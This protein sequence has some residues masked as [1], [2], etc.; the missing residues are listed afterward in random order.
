MYVL[1]EIGGTKTRVASSS[2]LTSFDEPII[3]ETPQDYAA[4][5]EQLAA[6]IQ[7]LG[8]QPTAIACGLPVRLTRDKRTIA[9]ARNLPA[10]AGKNFAADLEAKCGGTVV[11]ENDV[12]MVGL[13]EAQFGAG[14]GASSIIYMTVST[15]V[16]AVR[17]ADGEIDPSHGQY[18]LGRQYVPASATLDLEHLV[19]GKTVCEKYGVASPRDLGA[20]SA[21]WTELAQTLSYGVHNA[22]LYWAPSRVVLGG[23]MFNDIGIKV[24]QVA[25][26]VKALWRSDSDLPEIVH[27]K[28]TDRGGLWGAMARLKQLR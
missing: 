17:V 23:S 11:L 13:G 7:T 21:V 1:L 25:A 14:A 3:F 19:S 16:N 6:A 9:S 27:S 10:W 5:L 18:S 4:A 15:G 2:D 12:A 24:E 22:I 28:L 8:E 20:D 26:D